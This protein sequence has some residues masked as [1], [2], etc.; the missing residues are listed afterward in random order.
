MPRVSSKP[1]GKSRHDP[2]H[3]QLKE[4]EINEKYGNVSRPG[5]RKKTREVD[6]DAGPEV[7]LSLLGTQP[8]G[9]YLHSTGS[10]RSENFETNF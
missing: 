10:N 2:L 8:V 4:D 5:K 9:A 7:S 6:E 3:I 1:S